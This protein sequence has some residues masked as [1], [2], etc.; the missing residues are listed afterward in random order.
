MS[1]S[2]YLTRPQTARDVG[3]RT[4]AAAPHPALY[5]S[6]GG[7]AQAGSARMVTDMSA[8]RSR[9]S[10]VDGWPGPGAPKLRERGHHGAHT[11]A[12]PLV[13]CIAERSGRDGVRRPTRAVDGQHVSPPPRTPA[14]RDRAGPQPFLID[15]VLRRDAPLVP[16]SDTSGLLRRWPLERENGRAHGQARP[17]SSWG[18]ARAGGKTRAAAATR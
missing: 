1:R 2:R 7:D 4:D 6:P 11:S 9:R 5:R 15:A 18:A 14:D 13:Y 3:R 12:L 8:R 17:S 16:T 10:V